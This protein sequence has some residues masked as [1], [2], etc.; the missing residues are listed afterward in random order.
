MITSLNKRVDLYLQDNYIAKGLLLEGDAYDSL[1]L[2]VGE[3]YIKLKKICRD[4]D[5]Y[6]EEAIAVAL[7]ETPTDEDNISRDYDRP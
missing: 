7:E 3:E 6:I 2:R 4:A 1:V 5:F